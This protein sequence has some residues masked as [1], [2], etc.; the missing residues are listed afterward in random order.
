[1][2]PLVE[3]FLLFASAGTV[4]LPRG[5]FFL[6]VSV[7]ATSGIFA[8]QG[9]ALNADYVSNTLEETDATAE[10][11][12]QAE[13]VIAG[14]LHEFV[15]NFQKRLNQV[16]DA[17]FDSFFAMRPLS[18]SQGSHAQTLPANHWNHELQSVGTGQ[19]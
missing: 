9:T 5:W 12:N 15:D 14:G 19:S 16:G 10:I 17:I 1:M 7:I 11:E 13:D 3:G 18:A 6:A 4:A 2:A 8:A